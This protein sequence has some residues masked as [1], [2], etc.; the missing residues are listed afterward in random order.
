M[1]GGKL[2]TGG[3]TNIEAERGE[4]LVRR[5]AVQ[6]VGVGFMDAVN[7][8]NKDIVNRVTNNAGNKQTV[9]VTLAGNVMSDDFLEDEAIPKIK[10]MLRRGSDI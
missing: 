2:H 9:N 5:E 6:N 8:G 10:E 1:I 4:Y 7:T 3:G